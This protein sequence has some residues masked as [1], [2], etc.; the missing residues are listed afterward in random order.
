MAWSPDKR[1]RPPPGM[2]PDPWTTAVWGLLL[3]RRALVAKDPSVPVEV[4]GCFVA[5]VMVVESH[6][7]LKLSSFIFIPLEKLWT[8]KAK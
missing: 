8:P 4:S 6:S 2:D 7:L 5:A 1:V 3:V